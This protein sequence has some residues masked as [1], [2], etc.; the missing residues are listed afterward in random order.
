MAAATFPP[1]PSATVASSPPAH[2]G[3]ASSPPSFTIS[4]SPPLPTTVADRP[5]PPPATTTP[6]SPPSP[7]FVSALRSEAAAPEVHSVPMQRSEIADTLV[8]LWTGAIEKYNTLTGETLVLDSNRFGSVQ[9]TLD[10]VR[11][12]E[13]NFTQFRARGNVELLRRVRPLASIVGKLSVVIG[14]GVGLTFPPAKAI[15]AAIGALVNAAE[16]VHAGFEAAST[17]FEIM[18]QHLRIIQDVAELKMGQAL[19]DASIGLLAQ[20]LV[21]LAVITKVQKQGRIQHWLRA[22]TQSDKVSAAMDDLGRAASSHRHAVSSATLVIAQQTL[23][24]LSDSGD[25]AGTSVSTTRCLWK[26]VYLTSRADLIL[27]SANATN[28]GVNSIKSVI[29]NMQRTLDYLETD[30]KTRHRRYYAKE[31]RE[32]LKYPEYSARIN[33]LLEDRVASTGSWFFGQPI[34]NDVKAKNIRTVW[35]N[36]KVGCGKST[37]MAFAVHELRTFCA[38]SNDPSLVVAHFLDA[39]DKSQARNLREFL[40]S[41]LCQIG[42]LQD[43]Y[44]PALLSLYSQNEDGS[45]EPPIEELR[46]CL[47]IIIRGTSTHIFIVLDALDEAQEMDK[48]IACVR[49]L[50]EYENVTLLISSRGNSHNGLSELC[51]EH[52][53]MRDELLEG[54]V[55]E[56]VDKAL[57]N[58][59]ALSRIDS[60]L[61]EEVRYRLHNAAASSLH[62]TTLQVRELARVAGMPEKVRARLR[63]LP[64]T[65]VG[66]YSQ[67]L[68]AINPQDHADALRLLQWLIHTRTP[69]KTIDFMQ[70]MAFE[71]SGSSVSYDSSAVPS[72]IDDILALVGSTFLYVDGQEVR[73]SHASVADYLFSL[74]EDNPFHIR[75]EGAYHMMACTCLAFIDANAHTSAAL[76]FQEHHMVVHWPHY[77]H[78]AGQEHY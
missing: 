61:R 3:A 71:Y 12:H 57:C 14:E 43:D 68:K 4:E 6:P 75:R 23:T 70:L 34:F 20:I 17:A 32:W 64:E 55:K 44:H 9:S 24:V 73:L 27:V 35:L 58:D 2:A 1:L 50:R 29:D 36:G 74:P 22:L 66:Q 42:R 41:M 63:D 45:R 28:A 39:T 72:S 7:A 10:Y 53:I 52:I 38:A 37:T 54:D 25:C 26:T 18:M 67:S 5:P 48:I 78:D 21:V 62:W 65:L 46:K 30:T 69:L 49:Q 13:E 40:A 31:L 60:S 56:V 59:G 47:S 51:S 11:Q 76:S 15:F 19:R 16:C 77:L 8:N 33:H